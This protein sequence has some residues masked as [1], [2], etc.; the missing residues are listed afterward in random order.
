MASLTVR[1]RERRREE[2]AGQ[3]IPSKTFPA[4]RLSDCAAC[5]KDVTKG[6]DVVF[7]R[8]EGLG[9]G[10]LVH[11]ACLHRESGLHRFVSG[12]E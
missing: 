10:E 12:G 9:A 1:E 11:V 5:P 7:R 6:E 8:W 2:N 4:R 3:W